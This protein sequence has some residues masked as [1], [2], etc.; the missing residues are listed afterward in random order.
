MKV[1]GRFLLTSLLACGMLIAPGV[2]LAKPTV[3]GSAR[4]PRGDLLQREDIKRLS[5]RYS[6]STGTITLDFHVWNGIPFNNWEI[7]LTAP[8]GE[9]TDAVFGNIRFDSLFADSYVGGVVGES[10][11]V[12]ASFVRL[13]SKSLRYTFQDPILLNRDFQCV[14]ARVAGPPDPGVVDSIGPFELRRAG[15]Q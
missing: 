12:P 2:A 7:G 14:E 8:C 5:V 13:S 9:F 15:R 11:S 3:K 4:D 6:P 10:A 1:V